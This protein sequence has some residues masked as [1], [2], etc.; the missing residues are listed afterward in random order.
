L[1]GFSDV[2]K[3]PLINRLRDAVRGAAGRFGRRPIAALL[4][5]AALFVFR[6]AF[7]LSSAFFA[8]DQ[9]QI[10]LIGLRH[11]ATGAWPFFGPDV[12][13][14][15]SEIPGA[16]QGLLVG[17]P[18]R[19]VPLPESPF[20]LLNVLSFGALALLAWYTTRR[21]PSIPRWLVWG[22]FLTA[23]WTLHFSTH[24]DNA[25]YVLPAAIVF[26]IGFFEAT[27]VFSL[28]WIRPAAAYFM[29]GAAIGWIMQLHMSWPLLPPIAAGAWLSR[30][31]DG[32]R[33][34]VAYALCALCGAAVP[35]LLLIPTLIAFG[36]G[37]G[38]GGV[39]R[40]LHVHWMAPGTA[41]TTLARFLSFGS[42]EITRFLGTDNAK[43][44]EF[45]AAHP[46]IVIPA[47]VVAVASV[48]QPLWM[49]AAL[50]RPARRWP[51]AEGLAPWL[52]LRRLVALLIALV[53]ASYAFVMEAPQAHA[54]YALAPVALVVAAYC[55]TLIDSHRWRLVA[56]AL[57]ACNILLHSGIAIAR[58]PDSLYKHRDVVVAA[59]ASK[60]PDMLAHRRP[61]A[62]DAE[63]YAFVDGAP[64]DARR[65]LVVSRP[66]FRPAYSS[67]VHWT[68][69]VANGSSGV[70]Y[71]DLLYLTTYRAADGRRVER[72]A[73]IKDIFEPC[74]SRVV[75]LNDGVVG[76]PFDDASIAIIAAEALAPAHPGRGEPAPCSLESSKRA[77]P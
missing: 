34:L 32:A 61:F 30:R 72:Q 11:A 50:C 55:W 65:D 26:W 45:L 52:A 40:N 27:P 76:I 67:S 28:G 73:V 51:F 35:A 37:A 70:A 13:W 49:L 17:V 44:A 43:R 21:L 20:V 38:T 33:R 1:F 18:L 39:A 75:D 53:V 14:T 31:K 3:P 7:G 63:P 59:I 9:T 10:F 5:L 19:I 24:V 64:A 74:E 16:L 77:E 25:S 57:L 41:V 4:A 42:L 15:R 12:V 71:R 54:F 66:S 58:L 46:A 68:V 62:R 8:E 56:A 60:R 29:M 6:L 36:A 23:P 2:P 22:W 48:I 47:I 69:T